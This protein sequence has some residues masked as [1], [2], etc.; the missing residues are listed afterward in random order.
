MYQHVL[1]DIDGTLIDSEPYY[2]SC[3]CD[4]C[5][6][7]LGHPILREK[8]R[9]CFGMNSH[10]AMRSL[11]IDEDRL[12]EAVAAYDALCFLPGK[13]S[14][15]PGILELLS[16]LRRDGAHLAIYSARFEYEFSQDPALIP[17]LPYF[18]EIICVGSQPSKPDP[19]GALTYMEKHRLASDE[20]LYVGDS[21]I[22]SLT[23]QRAGIDLALCEWKSLRN[24]ERYP[25]RFY[26]S[27]PEEV[28]ALWQD[29]RR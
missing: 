6:R 15:C 26:C 8:A 7:F 21:H 2:V 10:A 5:Q 27:R 1:F 11:G 23:A 19:G 20:I 29:N 18:E 9:Y 16:A 24:T 13:I 12:P 28:L 3:L 17:L 4:V 25:A 14:P 22:D